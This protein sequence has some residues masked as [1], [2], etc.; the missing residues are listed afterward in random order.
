MFYPSAESEDNLV[1]TFLQH[2]DENTI[3][4]HKGDV[5]FL[6][7]KI[8][9]LPVVLDVSYTDRKFGTNQMRANDA[10]GMPDVCNSYTSTIIAETRPTD[11]ITR[12]LVRVA[13]G[14]DGHIA[15]G[16][17][18][19]LV[20]AFYIPVD[21]ERV[22]LTIGRD[23]FS[24]FSDYDSRTL[25]ELLESEK[26][27][28]SNV[29]Q[30]FMIDMPKPKKST[31][32]TFVGNPKHISVGNAEYIRLEMVYPFLY[33]ASITYHETTLR[34]SPKMGALLEC[35]HL[36]D[37][38]DASGRIR[39]CALR[40]QPNSHRLFMMVDHKTETLQPALNL[41]G[42]LSRPYIFPAPPELDLLAA[43]DYQPSVLVDCDWI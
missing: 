38:M 8:W 32:V 12:L 13:P 1:R 15:I 25:E 21:A 23:T 19:P 2:L 22:D 29:K 4:L 3:A 14:E 24:W 41:Y 39:R 6:K 7:Q 42:M 37:P 40:P 26:S 31:T 9:P 17:V 20:S 27:E 33:L 16:N 43:L 30:E 36:Q 28:L 34:I 5:A 35:V 11:E 10:T 18:A